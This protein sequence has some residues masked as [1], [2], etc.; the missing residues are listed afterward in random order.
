MTCRLL[1]LCLV[2]S[3]YHFSYLFWL[4]SQ[5]IDNTAFCESKNKVLGNSLC[6]WLCV[7]ASGNVYVLY[8]VSQSV[9]LSSFEVLR[10]IFLLF[11]YRFLVSVLRFFL[12]ESF[13]TGQSQNGIH[14][15]QRWQKNTKAQNFLLVIFILSHHAHPY[16]NVQSTFRIGI[17]P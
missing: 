1:T 16:Y 7:Y 4:I 3:H 13:S 14:H 10:S 2:L 17:G 8:D 12:T 5:I 15:F 9:R 11:I 6:A